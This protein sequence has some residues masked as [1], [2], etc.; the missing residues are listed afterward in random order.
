VSERLYAAWT[1][2]VG[3]WGEQEH[4]RSLGAV[5][6]LLGLCWVYDL[7]HVWNVGL[8]LP[9]FGVHPAGGLADAWYRDDKPLIYDLLPPLAEV[10]YG[11]HLVMTLAAVAFTLGFFTRTSAL[12]LLVAWA[13]WAWV[14]PYT[15]RGIDVLSR[16]VL[17]GM[18]FA[19][20]GATWSLDALWR[21]G[22]VF[23]RADDRVGA[24]ARRLLLV[25][26]VWMYFSAGILKT[27]LSWWPMGGCLA[28]YYAL[29]DPA[30]AAF[31]FGFARHAPWLQITQIGTLGTLIEQW[32]YPA[33]LWLMWLRYTA[34]RGGRLREVLNRHHYEWLWIAAG[35]MFHLSLALVMNLGIFPWAMLALYPAFFHPDDLA[36][37]WR[38]VTGWARSDR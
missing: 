37:G 31:D 15:D 27:G 3:F 13:Q 23:G 18:V 16:I 32:T 28:L 21:T 34:D 6:V 38:R 9:L 11:H 8:V 36:A 30:V 12:V 2:W 20:A 22:S 24:W 10:A 17:F 4:P 1:R 14:L 25:Q 29:Q 7:L 5:R 35:L 33:V 26:I 19:P